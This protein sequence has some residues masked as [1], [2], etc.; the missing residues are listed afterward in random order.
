MRRWTQLTLQTSFS[1]TRRIAELG[2]VVG[3][4][5]EK[6]D[7]EKHDAEEHEARNIQAEEYQDL[8]S[9]RSAA[10]SGREARIFISRSRLRNSVIPHDISEE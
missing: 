1:R 5:A 8:G 3:H 9:R 4:D 10:D 7:A 6:H 2:Q